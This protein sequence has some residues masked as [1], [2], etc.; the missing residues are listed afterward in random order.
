MDIEHEIRSLSAETAALQFILTQV[1]ARFSNLGA[2]F[3]GAI[4]EAFDDAANVAERVAIHF[5]KAA[6]PEQTVKA[7]RVVEE[8]RTVVLGNKNDPKHTV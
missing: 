2:P 1:L 5:G 4:S 3:H 8:L 6:S 7:L